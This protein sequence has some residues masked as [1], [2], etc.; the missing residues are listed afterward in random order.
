MFIGVIRM[1]GVLETAPNG[2]EFLPVGVG[3]SGY[4]NLEYGKLQSDVTS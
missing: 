2:T 1:L 3:V 4:R